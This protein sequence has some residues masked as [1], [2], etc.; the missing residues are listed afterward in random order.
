MVVNT[1]KTE[2]VSASRCCMLA[3]N[4]EFLDIFTTLKSTR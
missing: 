3:L 4:H 1:L 2:T